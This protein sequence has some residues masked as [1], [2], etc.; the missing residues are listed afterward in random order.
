MIVNKG[1]IHQT[2]EISQVPPPQML[3]GCE[4]LVGKLQAAK[5]K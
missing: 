3:T 2:G 5:N 1:Q 4:G